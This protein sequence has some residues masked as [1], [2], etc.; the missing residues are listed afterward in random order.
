MRQH[1]MRHFMDIECTRAELE[2]LTHSSRNDENV[3]RG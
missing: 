3:V 1:L 2:D